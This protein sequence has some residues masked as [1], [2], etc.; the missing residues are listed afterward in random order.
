MTHGPKGLRVKVIARPSALKGALDADRQ[1]KNGS[2]TGPATSKPASLSG[3]RSPSG[4]WL[5][6]VSGFAHKPGDF[7]SLLP[8]CLQ[9]RLR[10]VR[11]HL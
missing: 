5:R 9:L 2:N 7:L 3:V 10:M 11:L 4:L 1:V 8:K 6:L